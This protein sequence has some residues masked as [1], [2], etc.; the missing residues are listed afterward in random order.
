DVEKRAGVFSWDK[1]FDCSSK[2]VFDSIDGF[3]LK[4]EPSEKLIK[5]EKYQWSKRSL[6]K[7][8]WSESKSYCEKLSENGTDGWRLPTISELRSLVTNCP[9][10]EPGGKCKVNDLC[11][12]RKKCSDSC[13]V[14]SSK[15]NNFSKLGD[16]EMLWSSSELEDGNVT[17]WR[18]DFK[19]GEINF[20]YRS[21]KN[22]VRCVAE[23]P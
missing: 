21:A 16:T 15:K 7:L 9:D 22:F 18:I 8:S 20:D 17:V 4:N 23:K 19:T 5:K 3:D 10:N 1:R 2:G 6:E 13:T 14:C 12:D 11:L